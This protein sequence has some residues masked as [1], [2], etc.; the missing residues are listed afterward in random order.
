YVIG[1]GESHSVREFVEAAFSYAGLDWKKHVEVDPRYFR[2]TEVDY[3]L[4]DASK[5]KKKLGWQPKLT[6]TELVKVMV[7]AD[8]EAVGLK[9]V[10]E[11]RTILQAKSGNWHQ[12]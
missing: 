8:V 11:G 6:F 5:A 12:W 7:D 1:S 9:P 3:L 10:G 4:A 2:P